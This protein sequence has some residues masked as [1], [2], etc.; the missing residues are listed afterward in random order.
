MPKHAELKCSFWKDPKIKKLLKENPS[1]VLLYIYYISNPQINVIGIYEIDDDDDRVCIRYPIN[2][3]VNSKKSLKNSGL[4]MFEGN[5]IW[6]VGK[7][8]HLK[9]WKQWAGAVKL[10]NELENG[11]SLKVKF[12][13]K[14]EKSLIGYGYRIHR[15]S[16]N[17]LSIS[18][19]KKR[20][21]IS[22]DILSD[23]KSQIDPRVKNLIDNW[24]VIFQHFHDHPYRVVG[25]RD[26]KLFKNLLAYPDKHSKIGKD[27]AVLFLIGCMHTFWE[28]EG[29]K[30]ERFRRKPNVPSFFDS[31]DRILDTIDWDNLNF[32]EIEKE[33]KYVQEEKARRKE[34][35]PDS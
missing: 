18:I 28:M 11:L 35:S 34:K 7:A 10:L 16:D 23:K 13:E 1:A 5:F 20:N 21:N 29:E 19:S 3:F 27:K 8:N 24:C 33:L 9:G 26:G 30:E 2:K 22:K 4:V 32:E 31:F 15:V 25:G 6:I 12:A 17:A 14:Y